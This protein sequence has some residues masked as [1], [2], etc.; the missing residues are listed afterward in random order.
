[1]RDTSRTLWC[2]ECNKRY[3]MPHHYIQH[4]EGIHGYEKGR[5]LMTLDDHFCPNCGY[6]KIND[7]NCLDCG[8]YYGAS[9]NSPKPKVKSNED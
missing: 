7:V 2:P 8:F 1:M 6:P 5:A 4:L 3:V 9:N